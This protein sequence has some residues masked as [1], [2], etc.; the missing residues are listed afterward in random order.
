M[1]LRSRAH[2]ATL[3]VVRVCSIGLKCSAVNPWQGHA[4]QPSHKRTLRHASYVAGLVAFALMLNL[5]VSMAPPHK[6]LTAKHNHG[7]RVDESFGWSRYL[8]CTAGG[9]E[10]P[11]NSSEPCVLR[12]PFWWTSRQ[13]LLQTLSGPQPG[14]QV[15]F[16]DSVAAYANSLVRLPPSYAGVHI[17]RGDNKRASCSTDVR[18]VTA[19]VNQ[20]SFG[21]LT[22]AV[23]MTD[24]SKPSYIG[25]VVASLKGRGLRVVQLEKVLAPRFPRDNYMVFAIGQHIM[26]KATRRFV[27]RAGPKVL[28]SCGLMT[29]G[30]GPPARPLADRVVR[31]LCKS[32]MHER[33]AD[34]AVCRSTRE[35]LA[36]IAGP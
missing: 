14:V 9:V 30:S 32:S 19:Y 26:S 18:N 29:S 28:H 36:Q 3:M 17:R 20:T 34:D 27:W 16:S 10:I 24:E 1:L 13:H 12:P 7:R 15:L 31:M 35:A 21:N 4:Q 25:A 11:I 2:C 22:T 6:L 8:R 5:S 33:H 23:F